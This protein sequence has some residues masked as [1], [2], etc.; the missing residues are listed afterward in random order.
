MNGVDVSEIITSVKV[1]INI[2][3][4]NEFVISQVLDFYFDLE[5]MQ[6]E[7][8]NQEGDLTK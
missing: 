8:H 5:N 3:V 7:L 1:E 4:D 2:E 6:V